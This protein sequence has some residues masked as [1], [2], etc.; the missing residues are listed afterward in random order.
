MSYYAAD[1]TGYLGDLASTG[2]WR[3][4]R[5]WAEE[6]GA[7]VVREFAAAGFTEDPAALAA[8]V[9]DLG[10]EDLDDEEVAGILGDLAAYA[11][12]AEEILTVSDGVADEDEVEKFDPDQPRDEAGRWTSGGGPAGAEGTS[13]SPR[14]TESGSHLS[15][16]PY[17]RDDWQA[18]MPPRRDRESIIRALPIT[19]VPVDQLRATQPAPRERIVAGLMELEPSE[20][21]NTE[22]MPVGTK[23]PIWGVRMPDGKVDLMDGHHRVEA[24]WRKGFNVFPVRVWER[25]RQ[26][27]AFDPDQPR[28]EQGQWTSGGS[29]GAQEAA[30][31][32][33]IQA[34][35][36]IKQLSPLKVDLDPDDP[37]SEFD[38][39]D[40]ERGN[41]VRNPLKVSG[42]VDPS[43]PALT[44]ASMEVGDAIQ[45]LGDFQQAVAAGRIEELDPREL[46][47]Y[48][49]YVNRAILRAKL[50]TFDL[51]KPVGVV[52]AHGGK[53]WLVDGN[54]RTTIAV[55]GGATRARFI[56]IG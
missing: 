6:R 26:Q 10:P 17:S 56:R 43:Y 27:K 15:E 4:L 37:D 25:E 40:L 36:S 48:Q 47:T 46:L 5:A 52:F 29:S 30:T 3:A 8:Y 34:S 45:R 42:A 22:V 51:G 9:R 54:H 41:I 49:T 32:S 55:L 50:K 11:E 12:R 21:D 2:G 14:A 20:I 28:D 23:P 24:L 33:T 19:E 1:A 13:G 38:P 39:K 16:S 18:R 7:P 35:R 53:D 31:F 44:D